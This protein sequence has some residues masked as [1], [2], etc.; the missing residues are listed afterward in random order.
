M[1]ENTEFVISLDTSKSLDSESFAKS[2]L[3][4]WLSHS[5][6]LMKPERWGPG[7]PV[8]RHISEVTLDQL[9]REW[10]KAPLLFSRVSSPRMKVSLEWRRNKGLDPRPFPWGLIA[11]LA[12][13]GGPDLAIAFLE[14]VVTHFQPAFASATNYA[15]SRRKHFAKFPHYI[16][17]RIAGTAEGYRG[18]HVLNTL[19][20]VYWI[21]YFGRAIV[22]RIG[23]ATLLSVPVGKIRHFEDGYLLT[24]YNNPALIGTDEA[25]T[26]ERRI[27]EHLGIDKFFDKE[28]MG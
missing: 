3:S 8:R 13:I 14:L 5:V 28:Q 22:D 1:A 21:T 12:K 25:K 16:D 10:C 11:W 26:I 9:V 20:G 23:E 27:V 7:E 19:P 24:A 15:D 2:F 18:Q 6:E 4:A 17:G